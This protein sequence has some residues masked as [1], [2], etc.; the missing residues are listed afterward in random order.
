MITLRIRSIWWFC[1]G[2]VLALT[3]VWVFSTWRADA[4]DPAESSIVTVNPERILDS[5][6]PNNVGLPGPFLSQTP[7]K[8]KVTGSV[9]TATGTKVVVPTNA[10]GVVLNVTPVN[11]TRDGFISIEPGDATGT[12]T[13][14]NVNFEATEINPNTVTVKLPTTGPDA[15]RI[16]ITYDAFGFIG[17]FTDILIDVVGYTTN[18]GLTELANR[19]RALE[20]DTNVIPSGTTVTGNIYWDEHSH[21]NAADYR[22]QVDLPVTAPEKLSVDT[23]INFAKDTRAETFDDDPQCNGTPAAPTAPAGKV[24]IYLINTTR[25]ASLS[26]VAISP[27]NFRE[28][29]FFI[30]WVS[31]GTGDMYVYATWAYTAP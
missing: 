16:R 25:T 29:S 31:V 24:C 19:V 18:A 12:P 13:T 9:P 23:R 4:L 30:T 28:K 2:I 14:S 27:E 5:R 20:N 7:Q 11:A 22:L 26:G 15:G 21:V 8:L 17:P 6:D 10:T 3:S 1:T